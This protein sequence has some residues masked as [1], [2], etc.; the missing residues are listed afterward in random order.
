MFREY[1][2]QPDLTA[3]AV[4]AEGFFHTGDIGEL[5]GR[6]ALR[7]IDRKKNIFK[8]SQGAR[9]S[10]CVCVCVVWGRVWCVQGCS[11]PCAHAHAHARH[12]G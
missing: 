5:C 8:L 1:Y 10:V 2:K 11:A 4:D 6:G 3:E 7:I 9:G 12:A